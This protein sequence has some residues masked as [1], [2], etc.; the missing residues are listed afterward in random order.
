MTAPLLDTHAFLW[1][2]FDDTRLSVTAAAAIADA[3]PAPM[4]S[5]ASLWEITIKRQIGKLELGMELDTFF[6]RFVEATELRVL[7]IEL[8]HLRA[9]DV[10]PRLHRD[11]FDRLLVAQA[12][13]MEAPLVTSDARFDGYGV[14]L[15]W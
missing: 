3:D 5:I 2:L 12:R 1:Y 6:R 4:L 10:L 11:P 15:I 14:R 9:Y 13:A 8:H 7:P